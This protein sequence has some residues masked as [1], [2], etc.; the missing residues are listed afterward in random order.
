MYHEENIFSAKMNVP[1]MKALLC[2]DDDINIDD[3]I[4]YWD[5]LENAGTEDFINTK[6][7]LWS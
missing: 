7:D 2:T 4:K 3:V 1:K 6:I 5:S